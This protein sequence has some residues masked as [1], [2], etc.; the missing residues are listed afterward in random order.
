[1]SN[2]WRLVDER[3]EEAFK[4]TYLV[5]FLAREDNPLDP[6]H[7]I[8]PLHNLMH[9]LQQ[10]RWIYG[11]SWFVFRLTANSTSFALGSIALSPTEQ[12]R[13]RK[14]NGAEGKQIPSKQMHY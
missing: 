1:M 2:T 6:D 10:F 14:V 13:E 12:T 7:P 8:R 11:G 4:C 9:F 3:G 5:H